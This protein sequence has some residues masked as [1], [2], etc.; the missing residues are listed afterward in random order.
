[1]CLEERRDIVARK[2]HRGW[3]TSSSGAPCADPE[4]V[5]CCQRERAG[6]VLVGRPIVLASGSERSDSFEGFGSVAGT[7]GRF[8]A[9][10]PARLRGGVVTILLVLGQIWAF[11]FMAVA[12]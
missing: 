10:E 9:N 1:M 11:A 12:G 6:R 7:D 3:I 5:A 8:G 2:R 4:R